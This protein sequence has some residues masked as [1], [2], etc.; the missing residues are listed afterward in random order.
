MTTCY[1]LRFPELFRILALRGAQLIVMPSAFTRA[2]GAPHWESLVRARAIENGVFVVA[3]ISAE[4]VLTAS[5]A[6]GTR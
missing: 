4:P 2:T 3:P 1:D 5:P 6:T